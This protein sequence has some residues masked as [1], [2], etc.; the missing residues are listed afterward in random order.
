MYAE[1]RDRKDVAWVYEEPSHNN[2]WI[3]LMVVSVSFVYG[4]SLLWFSIISKGLFK[5]SCA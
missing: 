1:M 5:V 3:G 4:L 2:A